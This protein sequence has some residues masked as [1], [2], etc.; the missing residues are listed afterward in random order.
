MQPG[1]RKFLIISEEDHICP[2]CGGALHKRDKRRRVHKLEGGKK[3]WYIINR[4]KCERCGKLHNELPDCLVPYKHYDAQLI[5]DVVDGTVSEEDPAAEDYPCEGTMK[6]W[7]WWASRNGAN[8]NGQIRSM[9]HHLMDLDNGFLRSTD[10]LLKELKERIC[11]GWL[12]IVTRF[13]YNSGGRIE[14]FPE[15]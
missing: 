7:R 4:L 12:S 6:H 2:C 15:A 11:P 1:K 10:S 14:P 9:V 3:E 5:E 8:I 13:I